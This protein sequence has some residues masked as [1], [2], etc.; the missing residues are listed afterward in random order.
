MSRAV[1]LWSD[2]SLFIVKVVI[3]TVRND[4][5]DDFRLSGSGLKKRKNLKIR[6]KSHKEKEKSSG[7][8]CKV[9]QAL[10]YLQTKSL[11]ECK[12]KYV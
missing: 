12:R 10:S 9:F 1:G 8:Y 6:K 11:W 3:D 4:I 7:C 5:S 2:G